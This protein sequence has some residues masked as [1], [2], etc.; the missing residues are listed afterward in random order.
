MVCGVADNVVAIR[1]RVHLIAAENV[2]RRD[3]PGRSV[4]PED[5]RIWHIV[6]LH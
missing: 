5:A 1:I 6:F 2:M 3:H 4:Q